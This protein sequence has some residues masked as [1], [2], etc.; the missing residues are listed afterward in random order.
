MNAMTDKLNMQDIIDKLSLQY[1]LPKEDA[2]RFIV[3]LFNT[4]EL[5]LTSD[6]LIKIKDFGTFKLTLIQARE[7]VDV[8]TQEKIIIPSH[9]RVSFLPAQTLKTLVNKPFAHFETTPL[10]EGIVLDN[11][12]QESTVQGDENEEDDLIEENEH[13]TNKEEESTVIPHTIVSDDTTNLEDNNKTSSSEDKKTLVDNSSNNRNESNDEK[14]ED[15]IL[16]ANTPIEKTKFEKATSK[17]ETKLKRP[18]LPWYIAA[19]FIV[20]VIV[21]FAYSFYEPKDNSTKQGVEDSEIPKPIKESTPI[22]PDKLT[23]ETNAPIDEPLET[24]QMVAGKTL[25]LIALDKYGNRE[26]W[27]YIYF[28]NKDKIKNPNIIPVGIELVLPSKEE[29]D[30]NPKNPESVAKAKKLGDVEMKKFG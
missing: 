24:V 2:E 18:F 21:L 15:F 1:D 22:A 5:G 30:I 29:Y 20:I 7:S 10:N 26:F 23:N 6:E 28:K 16:E 11:V 17:S 13:L 4:I 9:Q 14:E 8:N 12:E 27:V 3:E 25:R 19:A